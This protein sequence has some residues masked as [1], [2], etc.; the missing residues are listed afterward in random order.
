M[1][2]RLPANIPSAFRLGDENEAI[3]YADQHLHLW[4]W[5]EELIQW[6]SRNEM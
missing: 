2:K 1:K 5:S 6:L 4:H 3:I